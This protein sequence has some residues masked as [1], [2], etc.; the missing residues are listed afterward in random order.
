MLKKI[1]TADGQRWNYE[2]HEAYIKL[3][4]KLDRVVPDWL[5]DFTNLVLALCHKSVPLQRQVLVEHRFLKQKTSAIVLLPLYTATITLPL[6][7]FLFCI[8][9]PSLLILFPP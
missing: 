1:L 9:I 7:S 6:Q 5:T 3:K 4:Q 2:I 8:I